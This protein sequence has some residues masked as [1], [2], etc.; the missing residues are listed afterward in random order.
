MKLSSESAMFAASSQV[1][2]HSLCL[3]HEQ[4]KGGSM[5]VFEHSLSQRSL[6]SVEASDGGRSLSS[7]RANHVSILGVDIG[8][9]RKD[10]E[11]VGMGDGGQAFALISGG[12]DLPRKVLAS[13]ALPS[14][15][16]GP[17]KR[18][19]PCFETGEMMKCGSEGVEVRMKQTVE[20]ECAL[21][22]QGDSRGPVSS[23]SGGHN[24]VPSPTS[25][26]CLEVNSRRHCQQLEKR[27]DLSSIEGL[28]K[29]MK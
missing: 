14:M 21:L 1:S 25:S 11:V 19:K 3:V 10:S 24:E 20:V 4:R 27:G 12:A 13:G 28:I 15:G 26:T 7:N 17:R 22:Q 23:F 2:P 29:P 18:R 5:E 6:P 9:L 16:S 8:G